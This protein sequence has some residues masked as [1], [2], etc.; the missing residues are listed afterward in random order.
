MKGKFCVKCFNNGTVK[1]SKDCI[2]HSQTEVITAT[3]DR[4]PTIIYLN[5][6]CFH[7][8]HEIFVHGRCHK[9]CCVCGT[10]VRRDNNNIISTT[11][12]GVK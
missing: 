2:E 4:N 8:F 10:V 7:C 9:I 3:V 12:G 1:K 6:V 11:T 5:R